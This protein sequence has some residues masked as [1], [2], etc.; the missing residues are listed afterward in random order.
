MKL[1]Y[2]I[3]VYMFQEQTYQTFGASYFRPGKIFNQDFIY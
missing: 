2:I 3:F 1:F